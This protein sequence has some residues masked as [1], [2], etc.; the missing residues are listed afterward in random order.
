MQ[1]H[2][3]VIFLGGAMHH[4]VLVP[5]SGCHLSHTSYDGSKK[6]C[7]LSHDIYSRICLQIQSTNS[8]QRKQYKTFRLYVTHFQ[9]VKLHM[10]LIK[11]KYLIYIR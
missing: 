9:K 1:A 8:Q 7:T 2:T 4:S 3:I 11:Y 10:I 5:A 6:C